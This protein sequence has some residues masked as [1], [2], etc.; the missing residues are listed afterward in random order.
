MI[1]KEINVYVSSNNFCNKKNE[2]QKGKIPMVVNSLWSNDV[3]KNENKNNFV[4][5]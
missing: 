5:I 2:V 3:L 1:D 4:S